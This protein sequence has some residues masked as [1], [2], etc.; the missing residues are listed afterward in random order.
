M[1]KNACG[2]LPVAGEGG[3][4]IGVISDRDIS[5]VGYSRQPNLGSLRAVCDVIEAF[6]VYTGR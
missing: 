2:F 4:V 5:I 3:N 6:Y 1:W